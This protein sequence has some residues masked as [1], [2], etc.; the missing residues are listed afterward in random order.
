MRKLLFCFWLLIIGISTFGAEKYY[1]A[2]AYKD[3]ADL[4]YINALRN[5]GYEVHAEK[6]Y[7]ENLTEAK[8]DILNDF[9][10]VI[11]TRQTTSNLYGDG[12]GDLTALWRQVTTPV[13]L[14]SNFITRTSRSQYFNTESASDFVATQMVAIDKNHPVFDGIT[15]DENNLTT[16]L[17]DQDANGYCINPG[18]KDAGNGNVI[19][20]TPASL[21]DLSKQNVV[22]IAK[23]DAGVTFYPELG[24]SARNMGP[25]MWFAGTRLE[26]MYNAEG[27]KLFL[28]AVKYM[29]PDK[30]PNTVPEIYAGTN[31][32]PDPGTN[33]GA[34][35]AVKV[36]AESHQAMG[37]TITEICSDAGAGENIVFKQQGNWAEY[38]MAVAADYYD[39]RF[40]VASP[41]DNL[42]FSE[43]DTLRISTDGKIIGHLVVR[44]TGGANKWE[45][46]TIPL[47]FE[48]AGTK[49]IRLEMISKVDS[50]KLNWFDYSQLN[51]GK[52]DLAFNASGQ[53]S[54]LKING[55]DLMGT[56]SSASFTMYRFDGKVLNSTTGLTGSTNGNIYTLASGDSLKFTFRIDTYPRHVSLHLIGVEGIGK[57]RNYGLKLV[58]NSTGDLG[59]KTL[60]DLLTA[61]YS[62]SSKQLTLNWPYLHFN[63]RGNYG[64][65]VIYK[66]GFEGYELDKILAEIWTTEELMPKHAGQASWTSSDVLNWVDLFATRF[67]DLSIVNLQPTSLKELYSMVDNIAIPAGIKRVWLSAAVWRGEYF[68]YKKN[69]S[70]V[71]TVIFPGG[72]ADLKAFAD[73]LHDNNISLSGKNVSLGV[74]KDNPKY[75]QNKVDRRLATWG[76]GTLEQAV[77]PNDNRILFRPDSSCIIPLVNNVHTDQSVD[78]NYMR[79]GEELIKIGEFSRTEKDVWVLKNVIRGW[80]I[81]TPAV[82]HVKGEE[83]AGLY[84]GFSKQ[85]APALDIGEE[86]SL[87]DQLMTEYAEFTNEIGWDHIHFDGH[88]LHQIYSPWS[89]RPI[90]SGTYAKTN[91]PVTTSQVGNTIAANFELAFSKTKEVDSYNYWALDVGLRTRSVNSLYYAT[92]FLGTHWLVHEGLMMG[93]R[94]L[95]FSPMNHDDGITMEIIEKHG[96]TDVVIKLIADLQKIIYILD[97]Q[98]LKYISD[99]MTRPSNHYQSEDVFV[100][101]KNDAD[102]YIWTPYHVMGLSAGSTP[103]WYN[104]QENGAI[105]RNQVITNGTTM[106]L[107]NPK[108]AQNLSFYIHNIDGT[109]SLVNPKISLSNGGYIEIKGTIKPEEY[110]GFSSDSTSAIRYDQDW[111]PLETL[112][113]T[114]SNF[115]VPQG[116]IS[117]TVAGSGGTTSLATQFYVKGEPYVLKTN[118]K[119]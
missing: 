14:M 81:P 96:L 64:G 49:T 17:I 63:E 9:H 5:A 20:V 67:N 33:T 92:N 89:G 109:R 27:I 85:Y 86:N 102:K 88:N 45:T 83:I 7:W 42:K 26:G 38:S 108:A 71:N 97:D 41:G 84:T 50:V 75:M 25:R 59:Y 8:K 82:S 37:G 115:A 22:T 43:H 53:V 77:G 16:K 2:F 51:L 35:P 57:E 104:D 61:S 47:N 73:Y 99:R 23:W 58:I 60:S 12:G 34:S 52:S 55:S 68:L 101:G 56:S 111:K 6:N 1:I 18:V 76:S 3:D 90:F 36:E 24:E 100:L 21:S 44:S 80:G 70:D 94:R 72:K 91:R 113:T 107:T 78:F 117:I 93:A 65:V 46:L 79:L 19:A 110:L 39:F 69:I 30:I 29:L 112:E 54:V 119:L 95:S 11:I 31:P 10:L 87:A 66:S 32:D 28:N 4:V 105:D 48:T 62:S 103:M 116:K 15:L 118:D 40:R 74:G 13:I 114:V 98:D 106:E